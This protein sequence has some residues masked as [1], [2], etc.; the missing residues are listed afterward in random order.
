MYTLAT[1][2]N[3][4]IFVNYTAGFVFVTIVVFIVTVVKRK[5]A[6]RA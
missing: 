6:A 5:K 2:T 4:D 3:R 1:I